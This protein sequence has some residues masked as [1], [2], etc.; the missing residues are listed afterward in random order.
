MHRFC[1]HLMGLS[2][3]RT[4]MEFSRYV[5][6]VV[7]YIIISYWE[8]RVHDGTHDAMQL[9]KHENRITKHNSVTMKRDVEHD[10]V[11]VS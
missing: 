2:P 9:T 8:V 10:I 3:R 4:S 1:T 11:R 5:Q 6:H 7:S